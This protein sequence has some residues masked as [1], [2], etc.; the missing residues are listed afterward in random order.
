[1]NEGDE[2]LLLKDP[3]GAMKAYNRAMQLAPGITEI[4]FWSALTLFTNGRE[5]EAL[6]L[7]KEVFAKEPKWMEVV[8]R[9]PASDLLPNDSGQVDR[10]LGAAK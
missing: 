7:F 8:R 5:D 1:M 6:K 2:K 10:I 4:R 9:L 3:E